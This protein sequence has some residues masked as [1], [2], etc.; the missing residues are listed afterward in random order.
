MAVGEILFM[1]AVVA[2]AALM[3]ALKGKVPAWLGFVLM[4]AGSV[5]VIIGSAV[6]QNYKAIPLGVAGVIGTVL[7]WI[8]G[9]TS[10]PATNYDPDDNGSNRRDDPDTLGGVARRVRWWAWL[11][12]AVLVVGAVGL[13][14]AI[15]E[16]TSTRSASSAL[17]HRS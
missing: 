7:I 4:I 10:E 8:S 16:A 6:T 1:V 3:T 15:P 5:A 11:V 12:A 9:A 2:V 17:H 13:S 14:F